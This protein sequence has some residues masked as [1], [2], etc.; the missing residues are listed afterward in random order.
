MKVKV[1]T[2]V[3]EGPHDYIGEL[4][5]PEAV[6]FC[7]E[8]WT[9]RPAFGGHPPFVII[10]EDGSLFPWGDEEDEDEDEEEE[11]ADCEALVLDTSVSCQRCGSHRVADAGGKCSD[12]SNFSMGNIDHDGYVPD[13]VG[14][15]G[16]DYLEITYC[17]D[18]GQLQGRY[19]L[20][21]SAIEQGDAQ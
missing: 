21:V 4:S 8:N 14:I 3:N 2:E 10:R 9:D 5:E 18:C 15:G 7:F 11:D 17:L 1:Y 19:P 16:G 13:G 20:P 12:M 6:R